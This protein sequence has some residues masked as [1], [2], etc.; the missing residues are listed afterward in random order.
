[1]PKPEISFR[2]VP[3]STRQPWRGEFPVASGCERVAKPVYRILAGD[4]IFAK[5]WPVLLRSILGPRYEIKSL[6]FKTDAQL[7]DLTH[8]HRFDLVCLYIGNI[9]WTRNK[10]KSGPD[11]VSAFHLHYQSETPSRP[12]WTDML[13]HIIATLTDIRQEF[14]KPVIATQGMEWRREFSGTGVSFI[15]SPIKVDAFRRAV[16]A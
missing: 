7:I 6:L 10:G 11:L 15:P 4:D 2:R 8:K 1:M 9:H 12:W 5:M 14:G 3:R 13:P 16:G